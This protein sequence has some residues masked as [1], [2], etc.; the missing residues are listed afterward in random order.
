MAAN[1]LWLLL[2]SCVCD[3][4]TPGHEP[5]VTIK[6]HGAMTFS[7]GPLK[8]TGERLLAT[9]AMAHGPEGIHSEPGKADAAFDLV[10]TH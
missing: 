10:H 3:F 9:Q 1:A 5:A 2:M 4:L 8:T 7:H 6:N